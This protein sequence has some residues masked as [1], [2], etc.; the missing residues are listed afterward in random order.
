MMFGSA[1]PVA[2]RH[3]LA[4][5]VGFFATVLAVNAVMVWLALKSFPGMVSGDPYREGLEYNRTIAAR[6]AQRALGWRVD[7]AV[8]GQGLQRTIEASFKDRDNAPLTG[9]AVTASLMR[10]VARGADHDVTLREIAPGIYR[11]EVE[12]PVPGHWRLD[13]EARRDAAEWRMERELWLD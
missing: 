10:P 11:A 9:L 8:S 1:R 4:L 12:F 2:G 3:V 7:V 6:E 5:V 13:I